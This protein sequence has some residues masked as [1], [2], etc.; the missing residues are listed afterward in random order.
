VLL[1][2]LKKLGI[3]GI[4]QGDLMFTQSD[5]KKQTI[6][7]VEYITFQ[8]NTIVYSVPADSDLARTILSAK[9]GIVFHTTYN[10]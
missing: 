6:N 7:G 4:V 8:P 2:E 1:P 3:K 9:V 5:L 10:G